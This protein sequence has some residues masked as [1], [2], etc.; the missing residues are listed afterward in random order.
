MEASSREKGN[1]NTLVMKFGGT[2]VG[3]TEAI[4]QVVKISRDALANWPRLVVIV[5]AMSG[6][7]DR[8]LQSATQAAAGNSQI[9]NQAAQELRIRH[10]TIAEAMVSDL[11]Q[12]FQ[13]KQE[14][15]YLITD[16][17]NLCQAIYVLGEATNRAMDTVAS[18]G[19]R[20]S[21]RLVSGALNSAGIPSQYVEATQLIV[22]D[23]HFQS[24][25]PDL[26]A[27]AAA[28]RQVLEPS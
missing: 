8:L 26:V 16:F 20:L 3:S 7:T 13:V 10:H 23:D 1:H 17:I 24:A 11:A 2:S 28:T 25:H 27:T 6:V 12:Q 5:S 18:L 4:G 14:I 22:T 21:V 9:F 15:N 19:E